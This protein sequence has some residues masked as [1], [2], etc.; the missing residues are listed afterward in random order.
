M[1]NNAGQTAFF[2]NLTGSGVDATN[3]QASGRRVPAVFALV[4]REGSHAPGTPSGV[5]F[6]G[7]DVSAQPV[8]NDAG[9]I[10]FAA[11][12]SANGVGTAA[13]GRPIRLAS[14]SSSPARATRWKW[15]PATSARSIR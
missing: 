3:D 5:N 2:A 7:F 1:L 13:F 8:L 11:G 9:Q 12:A 10:A 4:A 6:N 14:C 15:H